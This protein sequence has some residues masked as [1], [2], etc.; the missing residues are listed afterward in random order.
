[1]FRYFKRKLLLFI[2]LIG[3]SFLGFF[4]IGHTKARENAYVAC[5]MM[6]NHS[7]IKRRCYIPVLR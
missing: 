6:M 1:M 2:A 4:T 3:V 7:C 5:L